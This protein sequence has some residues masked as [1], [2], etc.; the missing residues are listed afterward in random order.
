MSSSLPLGAS[1]SN[2]ISL[3][4]HRLAWAPFGER[5]YFDRHIHLQK[6]IQVYLDVLYQWISSPAFYKMYL[7]LHRLLRQRTRKGSY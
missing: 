6:I 3:I 4:P 1:Q 5:A 2:L 7:L